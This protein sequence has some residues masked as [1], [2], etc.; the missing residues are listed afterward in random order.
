MTSEILFN[1]FVEIVNSQTKFNVNGEINAI[2]IITYHNINENETVSTSE[3]LFAKEMK[4]YM[5]MVLQ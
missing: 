2:P 4:Y 1:K 5:I 3:E